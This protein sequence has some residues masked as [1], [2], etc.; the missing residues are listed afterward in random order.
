VLR[1]AL[2]EYRG[3]VRMTPGFQMH[4]QS[5][6][7][8]EL[9]LLLA[10]MYQPALTYILEQHKVENGYYLDVGANLGF[11]TLMFAQWAGNRGRVAAFEAN[12]LMCERLYEGIDLNDFQVDVV[13]KAVHD[14]DG[15]AITFYVSASPGKSSIYG[16]QVKDLSRQFVI[17]TIT[18]DTYMQQAQWPRVDMI[19]IDIEG[20]DC[21][22]LLGAA[23]TIRMFR[24]FIVFEYGRDTPASI[25]DQTSDLL[26]RYNYRLEMLLINGKCQPFDWRVPDSLPHVDVLCYPPQT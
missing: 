11:F 1:D 23:T 12:P 20:N 16:E 26:Q 14:T 19:K 17:E 15:E 18:I 22:A 6:N 21:H 25:R 3:I 13:E 10:G 2:P 7:E 24:P 4:L 9:G 5:Q 8:V